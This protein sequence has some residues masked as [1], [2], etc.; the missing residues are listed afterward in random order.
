VVRSGSYSA[1]CQESTDPKAAARWVPVLSKEGFYNVS[2]WRP[3]GSAAATY[4]V[5]HARGETRVTL[6]VDASGG[7]WTHLGEYQFHAGIDGELM[8]LPAG[9]QQP[10]PLIAD[11]VRFA[12]AAVESAG[13]NGATADTIPQKSP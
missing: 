7:H 9:S 8:V 4:I 13:V 11:A 5:H 2:V 10:Q 1:Y 3:A 6:Q 12:C